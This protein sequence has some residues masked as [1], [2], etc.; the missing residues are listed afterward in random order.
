[1]SINPQSPRIKA[2]IRRTAAICAATVAAM[3]GMSYVAVPLYDLFCKTTGYGGTTQAS[4]GPSKMVDR[5]IRVMFD[6]NVDPKLPW[7]FVP[8]QPSIT[9][10]LGEVAQV[11]YRARNVSDRR[12]VGTATYNVTPYAL[13]LYFNKVQCFCFTQQVLEPGQE[14]HMPVLFYVEP[15]MLADKAAHAI[16]TASLSYT[17]YEATNSARVDTGVKPDSVALSKD[18][19]QAR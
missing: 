15:D 17:F 6:A 18:G 14:I 19:D 10:R 5:T 16:T 13:G 1:M 11:S 3:V 2:R 4:G 7:Q 9:V 12:I 8:D